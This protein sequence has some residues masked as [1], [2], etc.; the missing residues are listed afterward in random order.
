[1]RSRI[2]NQIL[3]LIA[4]QSWFILNNKSLIRRPGILDIVVLLWLTLPLFIIDKCIFL[5]DGKKSFDHH[6]HYYQ[7]HK[8][9]TWPNTLNTD[10]VKSKSMNLNLEDRN[11]KMKIFKERFMFSGIE[12]DISSFTEITVE[13]KTFIYKL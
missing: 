3:S 1:M 2:E 13:L 9:T 4:T 8:M 12:R 10:G 6:H 11:C 5:V 7:Q